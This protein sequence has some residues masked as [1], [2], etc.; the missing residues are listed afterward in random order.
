MNTNPDAMKTVF[1]FVSYI[2][3]IIGIVILINS[4][5]ILLN[6]NVN[7][8]QLIYNSVA[9]ILGGVKNFILSLFIVIGYLIISSMVPVIYVLGLYFIP[10]CIAPLTYQ[11]FLKLKAK[12]L[13]TTVQELT[14]QEKEDDYIDEYGNVKSE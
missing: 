1:L 13:N 12:A 8:K 5:I 9:L 6:M 7:F 4:P 3:L 2:A 14:K 10:L 11:S